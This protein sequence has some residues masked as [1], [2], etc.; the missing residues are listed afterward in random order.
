MIVMSLAVFVLAAIAPTAQP[1]PVQ[2]APPASG[3][4]REVVYKVTVGTRST[5]H[6]NAY[7]GLTS[8]THAT[9]DR[10]TVT[11]DVMGL[12]N[13]VLGVQVTE[14]M[15]NK[16][17]PYTFNGEVTA[18]GAVVFEGGS[19][20]DVTRELLQYFGPDFIPAGKDA[21][22]D[23]WTVNYDRAGTKVQTV[24]TIT[25]I[26]GE[27]VTVREQQQATFASYDAKATTNGT[28]VLKPSLLVPISGDMQKVLTTS[29]VTGDKRQELS[30]HFERSSDTR[31]T[32]AK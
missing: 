32:A 26:D 1:S 2:A 6:A 13:D 22:G 30:L 10:G 9:A 25:K 16:G 3:P 15:N 12:Q 24:F 8:D 4:L 14:L 5:A 11:V 23:S 31:E 17:S 28:I 7:E 29:D 27:L 19:I 21:V 20:E 18:D